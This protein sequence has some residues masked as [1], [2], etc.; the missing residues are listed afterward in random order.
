MMTLQ[1]FLASSNPCQPRL[2]DRDEEEVRG[3]RQALTWIHDQ[4]AKIP[5]S[6]ETVLQ[7]HRMTRG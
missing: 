5:V 2:G 1:L 6:D 3:S 4:G 7:L